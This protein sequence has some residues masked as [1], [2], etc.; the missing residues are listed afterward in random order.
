MFFLSFFL[1]L[2]A[3]LVAGQFRATAYAEDRIYYFNMDSGG[4]QGNLIL[5]ESNGSWGLLDA[6]HSSAG[7]IQDENGAVYST[8][9][10]GLSSQI[11][12]RNGK[13]VA[14]YMINV[15]GV[16][17]L[18]FVIGTHAH[19]DHIGGIRFLS[20]SIMYGLKGSVASNQH[21]IFEKF[22]P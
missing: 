1:V 6:G 7:T 10:H 21:I 5:V 15:L 17:H 19:S 9:V 2:G 12:C 11:S 22:S 20:P 4:L 14:N 8:M 13:D 3:M 18:D 16:S